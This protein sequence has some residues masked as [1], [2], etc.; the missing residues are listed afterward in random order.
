MGGKERGCQGYTGALKPGRMDGRDP[1]QKW[2]SGFE[3][4]GCSTLVF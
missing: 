2:E 1:S 4:V 3:N